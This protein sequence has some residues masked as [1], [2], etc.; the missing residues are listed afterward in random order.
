M[1]WT[2][3]CLTLTKQTLK[4]NGTYLISDIPLPI[5]LLAIKSEHQNNG[6]LRSSSQRSTLTLRSSAMW[7]GVVGI[8]KMGHE[9]VTHCL[10]FKDNSFIRTDYI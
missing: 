9:M 10:L 6:D 5:I 3:R 2:K 1:S 8:Y 4:Q 7:G